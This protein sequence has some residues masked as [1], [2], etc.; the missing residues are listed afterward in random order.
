[1]NVIVEHSTGQYRFANIDG[2]IFDKD[3]TIAQVEDYLGQLHRARLQQ[4]SLCSTAQVD[5]INHQFGVRPQGID[6]TGLLAVGSRW[7]N[8]TVMAAHLVENRGAS[9]ENML[10]WIAARQ[11]VA[12]AFTQ[13]AAALPEKATQ[14]PLMPGALQLLDQLQ[15]AGRKVAIASAD[16]QA[17]VSAFVEYHH[18]GPRLSHWQGVTASLPDKIQPDF[19]RQVCQ[20]M[21]VKPGQVLVCGDSASDWLMAQVGHVVG[22]IGFTGGWAVPPRL[23]PPEGASGAMQH[24]T[25]DQLSCV[26]VEVTA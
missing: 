16:S 21:G 9:G 15:G 22:F 14:T 24:I 23:H 11:Q 10:S 25:I 5:P 3:G 20:S 26:S 7:E 4:L 13:A 1:M 8:E 17:A 18:L 12:A 2:V 6:P 19:L